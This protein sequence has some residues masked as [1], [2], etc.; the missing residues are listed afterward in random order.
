[1]LKLTAR[2]GHELAC[3]NCGAPLHVMKALPATR[4]ENV[5]RSPAPGPRRKVLQWEADD[6][7]DRG[8]RRRKK[9][10]RKPH[11]SRALE[12]AIDFVEDIFD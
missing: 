11:W 8:D 7:D 4:R 5:K 10:R 12:E 6:W 2:S 1:M 9:K 3:G